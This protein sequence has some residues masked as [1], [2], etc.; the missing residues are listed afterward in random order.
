MWKQVIEGT[1]DDI[2][3]LAVIDSSYYTERLGEPA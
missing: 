2:M 3:T 1:P